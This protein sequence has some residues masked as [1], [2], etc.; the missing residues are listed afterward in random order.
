MRHTFRA[1]VAAF[2]ESQICYRFFAL[3][4]EL[5]TTKGPPFVY[6]SR[7]NVD[8]GLRVQGNALIDADITALQD[9]ESPARYLLCR[10]DT[11]MNGE[12]YSG[13]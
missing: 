5:P 9:K 12:D 11:V 8:L 6:D 13:D 7:E 4:P 10:D 1:E 2:I 3:A